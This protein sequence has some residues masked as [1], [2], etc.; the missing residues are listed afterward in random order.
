MR[1]YILLIFGVFCFAELSAQTIIPIQSA[2]F[3]LVLQTDT[4]QRLRNVYFGTRL[5]NTDEYAAISKQL[6]YQGTN[7]DVFNH[8]YTPSGTWNVSEPA[9]EVQHADGNNSL[10]L[11]YVSHQKDVS[12]ENI[13]TY[14]IDLKD[15]VYDTE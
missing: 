6:R 5:Q 8:A 12:I 2:D 4:D 15:P 3:A 11:A 9:I 7:E 13:I 1:F 14:Q 10:E